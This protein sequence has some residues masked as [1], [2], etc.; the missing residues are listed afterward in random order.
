M[1]VYRAGNCFRD[2]NI[3]AQAGGNRKR[4]QSACSGSIGM[5]CLEG[6]REFWGCKIA[7]F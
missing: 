1:R 7:V 4:N 2:D 3:V 5:D 6:G